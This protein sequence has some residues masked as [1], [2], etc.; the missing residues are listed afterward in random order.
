LWP[1]LC[2]RWLFLN[3]SV[4]VERFDSIVDQT[5]EKKR[6][7]GEFF[8]EIIQKGRFLNVILVVDTRHSPGKFFPPHALLSFAFLE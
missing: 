3:R 4:Y 1:R 6:A 8:H 2:I 7:F 5:P